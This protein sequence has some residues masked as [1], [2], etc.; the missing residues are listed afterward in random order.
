MF[1]GWVVLWSF[2]NCITSIHKKIFSP[3]FRNIGHFDCCWEEFKS[4]SSLSNKRKH[5]H[6]VLSLQL[7]AVYWCHKCPKE[8]KM[9]TFSYFSMERRIKN[10]Q[11]IKLM[12]EVQNKTDF[13]VAQK[14][15]QTFYMDNG[16]HF[17]CSLCILTKYF[18]ISAPCNYTLYG[19]QHI[20]PHK[21]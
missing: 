14:E 11:S 15:E 1:Y 3:G 13:S 16:N 19:S 2:F 20:T 21:N 10:L 17:L 6:T 12:Y 18:V 8:K 5:F 4:E 7:A 9:W